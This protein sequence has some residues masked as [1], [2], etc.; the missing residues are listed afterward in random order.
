[1]NFNVT[2]ELIMWQFLLKISVILAL[3]MQSDVLIWLTLIMI[4]KWVTSEAN[5]A[6]SV[7]PTISFSS[8]FPP[9]WPDE[10]WMRRRGA[11]TRAT[12]CGWA[13]TA[14]DP[15]SLPWLARS[16]WLR[17]PLPSFPREHQWTVR[18]EDQKRKKKKKN[19][20]ADFS[21]HGGA[22]FWA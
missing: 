7:H 9:L 8:L 22:V 12:F 5:F 15:K 21:S 16:E 2:S 4:C 11:T 14:G 3:S 20:K 1:M 19:P 6:S 10:S 17:E 18:Q 13:P